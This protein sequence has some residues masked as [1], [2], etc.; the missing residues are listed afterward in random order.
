MAICGYMLCQ[1]N[2]IPAVDFCVHGYGYDNE[3]HEIVSTKRESFKI[4]PMYYNPYLPIIATPGQ[5][6]HVRRS[7]FILLQSIRSRLAE[8]ETSIRFRA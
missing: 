2:D 3:K 8:V 5:N 4:A 7:P 1:D 6:P